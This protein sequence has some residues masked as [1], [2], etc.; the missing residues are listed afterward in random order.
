MVISLKAFVFRGII[1]LLSL[2]F[3]SSWNL[4]SQVTR[5]IR[6]IGEDG[7]IESA[8]LIVD[9]VAVAISD[10]TGTFIFQS[11]RDCKR[12][13]ITH[14]LYRDNEFPPPISDT[15]IVLSTKYY[16]LSE[17]VLSNGNQWELLK[18]KLK[19]GLSVGHQWK[20]FPFS[21][22]DTISTDSTR[23]ILHAFGDQIDP[24]FRTSPRFK[25]KD[26]S[27]FEGI[28]FPTQ[29]IK[30]ESI[31]LLEKAHSSTFGNGKY[32]S[33]I[34]LEEKRSEGLIVEYQGRS[35]GDEVF[36]FFNPPQV[37]NPQYKSKGYIYI[38]ALTGVLKRIDVLFTPLVPH[39]SSLYDMTVLYAYFEKSNSVMP[40]EI[41]KA[42]YSLDDQLHVVQKRKSY[43]SVDMTD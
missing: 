8:H 2:L 21:S 10:S 5:K 42:S 26:Y 25:V 41:K 17:A 35:E 39:V 3:L 22:R 37:N 4:S 27:S 40:Q 13:R 18:E 9:S 31:H 28:F 33:Y 20:S 29:A 11:P 36:R 12:I 24:L 30:K 1:L 6:V 23:V 38:D 34:V 15:I 19:R 43:I 7:P 32:Y 14:L 16:A